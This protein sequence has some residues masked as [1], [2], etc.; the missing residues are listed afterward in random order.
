MADAALV[1]KLADEAGRRPMASKLLG[2]IADADAA[3][4][5]RSLLSS[6][7]A[8]VRDGAL[9]SLGYSGTR[10]D[11]PAV[12][13]ALSDDDQRVRKAARVA[14]AE[15]G[16]QAA[17]DALAVSLRDALGD[18]R[19][20]IVQALA[21]LHD[22]RALD[23]AVTIA[24]E[25]IFAGPPFGG[26]RAWRGGA[27]GAVRL[28]GPAWCDA[29]EARVIELVS[30]V[31]HGIP[32][33]EN[34]GMVAAHHA[35]GNFLEA[36]GTE[37]R[38]ERRRRERNINDHASGPHAVARRDFF[39]RKQ[40]RQP[41]DPVLPRDVPKLVFG[42]RSGTPGRDRTAEAKFAGQPDWREP[43]AWPI[44]VEGRPLVFYG[45][46][47]LLGESGRAAYIFFEPEGD[48]FSPLGGSNALVIQPGAPPHL[49]TIQMACGPELFRMAPAPPR[50]RR[51]WKHERYEVFVK[52][53]PSNDPPDW[54][55][56]D[57]PD[58]VRREDHG[59]WNKVGGTPRFL[60]GDEFPPG[61]EWRF[62]FQFGADFTGRDLGDGAECYGFID[63]EGRGA[64]LWQCH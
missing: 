18:D 31:D 53:E 26:H 20:Q 9:T 64:F 46:V 11:V 56:P 28:A 30:A 47:P 1:R 2:H 52:L 27:W 44:G 33:Q 23:D 55:W 25:T 22:A 3:P 62:A 45:Q 48:H 36:V 38:G 15:L 51:L 54:T 35:Q 40:T 19:D 4:A 7:D 17:A 13:E 6:M 29:T 10:D 21:W 8:R 41:A 50:L 58:V 14:L 12:A 59:D 57:E 16:G 63:A 39:A 37:D 61:N 24:E 34:P 60:Q 43:P 42:D 49:P 5:L 32:W